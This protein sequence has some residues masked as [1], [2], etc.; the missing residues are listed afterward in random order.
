MSI[1]D[2]NT[3]GV[4]GSFEIVMLNDGFLIVTKRFINGQMLLMETRACEKAEN[5]VRELQTWLA[6]L[7]SMTQQV[8]SDV[9]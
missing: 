8:P 3:V 5:L 7:E 9:N 2:G 1:V 6:K 4:T